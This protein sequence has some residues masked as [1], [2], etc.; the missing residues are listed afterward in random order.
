M[1]YQRIL[2]TGGAGFIGQTLMRVLL[3][4]GHQVTCMDNF[5]S[6]SQYTLQPF[7]AH[8]RFKHITHDVRVPFDGVCDQIYHLA[9]PASPPRYQAD[10]IATFQAAVWGTYHV[11]DLARRTGA[12]VV[13]ASTSEV[14][15]DPL[16]HPQPESY[17][18]HVNPVGIRSC[19]D[20]GKRASETLATDA[21]RQWGVDVRIVRIF[22]TYG[23][24]MD[25]DDGRVVSN[26]IMQALQGNPLTLYGN[27][28]QTRSFCYVDDLVAGLIAAMSHPTFRGPV[29]LGNP[30]EF[31]VAELAQH[32]LSL[33]QSASV[34][35]Y[36]PLPQDDPKVRCP[37]IAL[38]K[39]VYGW[40]P[41]VPLIEGL[42]KT[43]RYFASVIER[44]GL[45]EE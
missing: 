28:A 9:C 10:P 16:V 41:Q 22:N 42:Q 23:P 45:T 1:Q 8:P 36:Q 4:M 44:K 3:D 15:G 7:L 19:Y 31:T 11:L 40:S 33:T 17:W 43:I 35:A 27:G 21:V 37:D 12:R 34:F 20:E 39:S 32:V 2:V 6:S 30:G 26:F 38:A 29:N 14:Y 13:I 5:A 18:G 24:G 25:P